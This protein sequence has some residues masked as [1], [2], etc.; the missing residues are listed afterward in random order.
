MRISPQNRNHIRKCFMKKDTDV[1]NH[2]QI[3]GVGNRVTLSLKSGRGKRDVSNIFYR[4]GT[5]MQ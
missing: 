3:R 2:E 5:A 1:L 4:W